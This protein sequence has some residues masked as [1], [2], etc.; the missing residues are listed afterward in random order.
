MCLQ[1]YRDYASAYSDSVSD[2]AA[3]WQSASRMVSWFRAPPSESILNASG[4]RWFAGGQLNT[5]YNAL[6]VHVRAGRGDQPAILYDSPLS[7]RKSEM[8]Y[9]ALLKLTAELAGALRA[10]GVQKGDTVVIYMPMIPLTIPVM[11]ACARIGAI[12]S[13]VF[14]GFAGHEL[15]KRLSDARPKMIFTASCGLEPGKTIPYM[16]MVNEAIR[17]SG[18]TPE[19]VVVFQREQHKAELQPGRDVDFNDFLSKHGKYT[20][21]ESLDSTDPLYILYTSGT[22][23]QHTS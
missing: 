23:A 11:L 6:D 9:S 14:G 7:G 21:C 2:P 17:E 18:V 20:E 5:C 13:V 1:T 4:S 15:A 10:H 8:S 12:H 19:R 22:D 3:F 16:P